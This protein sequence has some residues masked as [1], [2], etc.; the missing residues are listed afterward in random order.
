MIIFLKD[1]KDHKN[2]ISNYKVDIKFSVGFCKSC[3]E[4]KFL[5]KEPN[6]LS[7]GRYCVINSDFRTCEPVM[8]TLRAICVRKLGGSDK[9]IDYLI[10]M[11]DTF[12]ALSQ[13]NLFYEKDF[14]IHSL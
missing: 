4:K 7:G 14:S 9:L 11:K 5:K 8:E 2:L 10:N 1:L 3:K 13:E 12:V 6:C